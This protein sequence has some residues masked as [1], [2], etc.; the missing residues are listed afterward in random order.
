MYLFQEI[1]E[2]TLLYTDSQ[3]DIAAYVLRERGNLERLSMREIAEATFT[4]KP[5]LTRFAQRFGFE[6]WKD[7]SRALVAEAHYQET[8]Y[9]DVDPNFPFAEDDEPRDIVRKI[10]DL[11]VE[12]ILDTADQLD[13]DDLARAAKLLTSARRIVVFAM[14]P[15]SLVAALFKRKMESIGILVGI[16]PIDEIGMTARALGPEDAAIMISYSGNNPLREPM[17]VIETLRAASVPLIGITS[18]GPNLVRRMADITFTISSRERLFSKIANYSTEISVQHTLDAL[19]SCCFVLDYQSNLTHKIDGSRLLEYR[20]SAS[21][22]GM[23]EGDAVD[24]KSGKAEKDAAPQ[25]E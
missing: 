22:P 11:Q 10:A 13:P 20:R 18:G 9:C 4:S 24:E 23:R 25:G 17:S 21:L 19:F 16:A 3:R 14:S 6:G 5:T 12:S 7:F 1:E 15:N 2:A 8:H